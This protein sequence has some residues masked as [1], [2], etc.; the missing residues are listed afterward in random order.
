MSIYGLGSVKPPTKVIA[1]E[2][3]AYLERNGTP[4]RPHPDTGVPVVWGKGSSS[5][6]ATGRALDFMVTADTSVGDVIADY[7]WQHRERL[8]LVHV[9]WRQRIKSTQVQ[10]GVWR[11]MSD[12]GSPTENHMDHPHCYFDGRDVKPVNHGGAQSIPGSRP[13]PKP[14]SEPKPA[15]SKAPKFPL[16]RGHYFGPKSGPASSVSGYYS[17]RADLKRWQQQMRERGWSITAD[18]LYG[19][20]TAKVARAF[21]RE[22]GLAVDGLIGAATWAAAWKEPVT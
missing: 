11:K 8:G 3:L 20:A 1:E 10:P 17:H 12:R 18:G 9:I 22:K 2:V 15:A 16:P 19:P 5:E 14:S 7:V 13:G 21:Q 4:L 6:H